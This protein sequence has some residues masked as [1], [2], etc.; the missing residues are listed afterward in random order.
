MT[1]RGAPARL[2]LRSVAALAIAV[3]GALLPA[4]RSARARPAA[5]LCAG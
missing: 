5:A 3:A 2:A 4:S 1:Q